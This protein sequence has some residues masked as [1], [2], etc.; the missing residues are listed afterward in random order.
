MPASCRGRAAR[1]RSPPST[2]ATAATQVRL[3]DALRQR[4]LEVGGSGTRSLRF[5]PALVFEARHVGEAIGL[6]DD[7]CKACS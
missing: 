2:R 4:G 6:L 1:A 3:L 5:R 7:A